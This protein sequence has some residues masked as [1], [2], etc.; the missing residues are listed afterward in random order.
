MLNDDRRKEEKIDL[1]AKA[2]R[3]RE[4]EKEEKINQKEKF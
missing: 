4:R 2:K 1:R 3:E